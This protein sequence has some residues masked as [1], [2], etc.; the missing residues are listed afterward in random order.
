MTIRAQGRIARPLRNRVAGERLMLFAW[1]GFL[2]AGAGP[3]PRARIGAAF[4]RD[5]AARAGAAERQVPDR[6]DGLLQ[7]GRDG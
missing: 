5:A 2:K 3:I 4:D 7:S 6:A 1:M